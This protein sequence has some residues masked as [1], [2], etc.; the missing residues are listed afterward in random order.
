MN[1]V[2]ALMQFRRLPTGVGTVMLNLFSENFP[3]AQHEMPTR[4]THAVL[5]HMN[6]GVEIFFLLR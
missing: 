6:V 2:K 5:Q 4:W 3:V 1:S